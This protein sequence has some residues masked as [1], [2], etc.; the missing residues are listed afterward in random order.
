M[1]MVLHH[2]RVIIAAALCLASS[3]AG[4]AQAPGSALDRTIL[5]SQRLAQR[6][7]RDARTYYLLGD[8]YAQKARESG[9]VSYLTLAEQALR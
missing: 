9:D 7:P 3:H 1:T 4:L 8:A 2:L 6:H 5:H